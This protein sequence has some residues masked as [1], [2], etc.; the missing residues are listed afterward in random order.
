MKKQKIF[1][2]GNSLAVTLPF[3]VVRELGIKPGQRVDVK[4]NWEKLKVS[5]RFRGVKQLPLLGVRGKKSR[6]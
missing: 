3:R 5:Y 4:V 6:E 2:T 1:R